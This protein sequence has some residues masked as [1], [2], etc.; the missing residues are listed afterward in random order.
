MLPNM[1]ASV[2][3]ERTA[4]RHAVLHRDLGGKEGWR[5]AYLL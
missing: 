5:K 1:G 2:Q 4:H 3:G